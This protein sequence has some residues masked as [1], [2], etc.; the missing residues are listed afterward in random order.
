M[1]Q[2]FGRVVVDQGFR[3]ALVNDQTIA[4]RLF[5]VVVPLVQGCAAVANAAFPRGNV[6]R[7]PA[8]GAHPPPADAADEP[9]YGDVEVDDVVDRADFFQR[10]RL[11][12]CARESIKEESV[13]AVVALNA[14]LHHA[15]NHVVRNE[16]A[17]VDEALGRQPK[18]GSFAHFRAEHI[19]GGDMRN[20]EPGCDLDRLC[21]FSG[22]WRA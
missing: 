13:L 1:Q 16:F 9:L 17:P 5:L 7:G 20:P 12:N 22:A 21:A 19:P 3:G 14:V 15:E 10:L 8:I 6:V 18:L 4:N 2:A 11:R